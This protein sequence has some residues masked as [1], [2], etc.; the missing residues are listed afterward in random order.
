VLIAAGCSAPGTGKSGGAPAAAPHGTITLAFASADLLPV[1]TTFATLVSQDSGGHLKLRPVYYNGRS[2]SA[3]E[4]IAAALQKGKLAVADVGSRAWESLGVP[5]FSAYQEPF[6]VTSRELLDKV[7][8]GSVAAG[9]LAALKP[10]GIT[11]LAIAPLSIRYLFSTRPLMT[12]AQF[13]GAKI[14]INTSVTTSEVIHDLG[15]TPVTSVETGPQEIRALRDGALTAVEYDPERAD[16]GFVPVAPYVVVNAPL[17][18]KTTTFAANSAQLARLPTRDATWLRQAAQQAAAT[19]AT[20]ATDRAAWAS[21]CAQ[22]LKP[23]ALTQQQFAALH[24]AE[25]PVYESI[26]AETV[27]ALAVDRIG[28]LA[29]SEPRMDPWATCHGVGLGPSPTKVLDGS[30]GI[31]TTQAEVAA[32]GDCTDCGNAG[33][34]RLVIHDGR[35]ALYHPVQINASNEEPGVINTRAWRPDDPVEVGTIFITG[36]QATLVP[37]TNQIYGSVPHT[38][39]FELFRG[40]LTWRPP[41]GVTTWDTN[42][43]W[44]KLN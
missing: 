24:A 7:V 44:R 30:Y 39:G 19:E 21:L 23:L 10:V 3:D 15:A 25:A 8:T 18:A 5:A 43:P 33:T 16:G 13:S 2:P 20:S 4:T 35:Y 6:L 34:F 12:L 17:F 31:T 26:A 38:Y 27:P 40:M 36:K 41:S 29:A 9:M 37:D 22:G 11:G 1:D 42:R 28:G 32:A 14:R